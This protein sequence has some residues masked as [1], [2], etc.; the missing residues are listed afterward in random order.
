M[1]SGKLAEPNVLIT[2]EVTRSCLSP[3]L[4]PRI[5]WSARCLACLLATVPSTGADPYSGASSSKQEEEAEEDD[6]NGMSRGLRRPTCD[7]WAHGR[8][9]RDPTVLG[10]C[11]AGHCEQEK[12]GGGSRAAGSRVEENEK[13][14]GEETELSRPLFPPCPEASSVGS[15]M[16]LGPLEGGSKVSFQARQGGPSLSLRLSQPPL[17]PTLMLRN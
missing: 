17:E 14:R 5:L 1:L 11:L 9:L 7:G 4:P 12:G 2:E 6:G 8:L 16:P 13:L 10:G 3:C 15:G